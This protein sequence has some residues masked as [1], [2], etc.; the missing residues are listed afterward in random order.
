MYVTILFCLCLVS[1]SISISNQLYIAKGEKGSK[2][3]AYAHIEGE[4]VRNVRSV[5]KKRNEE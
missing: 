2:R 4:K 3:H 5:R 1:I